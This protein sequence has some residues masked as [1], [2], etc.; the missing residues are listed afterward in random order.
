MKRIVAVTMAASF[1][2]GSLAQT[3]TPRP[4]TP[5]PNAITRPPSNNVANIGVG[6]FKDDAEKRSYAIGVV[7]S[8]NM[9]GNL[10]R[11]GYEFRPEVVAKAFSEG[12]TSTNTL[13]TED[14][15]KQVMNDYAREMRSKAEEKR[16]MEAEDNK[17][18]G[19]EFLDA[20][21][22]KEGVVTTPSGLQYKVL[23]AGTGPKPTATDT[24]ICNYRGTLLN[25]TE[26]DSSYSRGKPA[27]F[28]LSRVVKGWTEGIQLMAVGSKYQ[29][30]IPPDLAYGPSGSPPKIGPNSTLIFEVELTGI[31]P[32]APIPGNAAVTSD[33]IKVPSQE[34]MKKGAK[35]EVIKASEVDKYL[36]AQG[37]TNSPAAPK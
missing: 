23:T 19:Q 28:S 24:V 35:P 15:A 5:V 7:I 34:E 12:F 25:G 1:A 26:F 37:A 4:I 13:I 10:Q 2:L 11:G 32:S 20:N 21:K 31:K 14:E 36:K 9:K 6:K 33:I 18:K 30:F 22:T 17:K 16:K 3:P 8:A 27:D 29:F